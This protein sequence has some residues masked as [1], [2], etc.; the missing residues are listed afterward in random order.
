[1]ATLTIRLPDSLKSG[2]NKISARETRRSAIGSANRSDATSPW[3][4]SGRCE[5]NPALRRVAGIATDEE[6]FKALS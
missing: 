4:N 1:M 5:K 3:K 6:V 2:L